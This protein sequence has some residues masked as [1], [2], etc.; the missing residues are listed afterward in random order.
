MDKTILIFF[1]HRAIPTQ[2][3]GKNERD[4]PFLFLPH[5]VKKAFIVNHNA[6]IPKCFAKY[7]WL[8]KTLPSDRLPDAY[9]N[10]NVEIR[11]EIMQAFSDQLTQTVAYQKRDR[12]ESGKFPSYLFIC[13]EQI[14]GLM[15]I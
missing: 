10:D 14:F 7:A 13:I 8:T 9:L 4:V 5:T 2:G 11:P 6:T 1:I 15:W 12:R 3:V